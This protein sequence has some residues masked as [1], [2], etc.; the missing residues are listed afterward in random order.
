[1]DRRDSIKTLLAGSIAC[2]FLLHACVSSDERKALEKKI[3]AFNNYGRTPEEA[4]YDQA[5]FAQT[6]FTDAELVTLGVL[7]NLIL[8][9]TEHGSIEEA[10]VLEFIEFIVKDFTSFQAPLRNGLQ[11]LDQQA[12]DSYG[13]VFVQCTEAAQKALLDTMAFPDPD[14]S[15]SEQA[16][17]VQF[18]SLLRN[19]VMTGYY[20]AA[21]GI[22]ELGYKGNSPNIWDGVPQEVL[23][24][25]GLSYDPVWLSKCLDTSKRDEIA[26]WDDQGNLLT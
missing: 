17:Q 9:P 15:S 11:T 4:A 3:A 2:G 12:S 16:P 6:F 10:K 14:L 23:D 24:K 13:T 22:K 7:G 1:M 8:P 21:V 20:T 5:L 25:H 18:F 26:V 19:L